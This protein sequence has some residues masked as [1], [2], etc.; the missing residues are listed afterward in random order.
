MF[1]KCEN[2]SAKEEAPG[3]KVHTKKKKNSNSLLFD[4]EACK[5]LWPFNQYVNIYYFPI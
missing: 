5:S 1:L 3:N 2:V 4:D